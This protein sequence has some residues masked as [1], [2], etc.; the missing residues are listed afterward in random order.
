MTAVHDLVIRN[1][2]VVDGTGAAPFVADVA[3][4]DGRITSI[5]AVGVGAHEV[6][7]T[8]LLVTPGFVD[9]HTHF[10]GQATWDR[11]LTPS[12]WHGVTTAIA[13]NCGVGFAP[14]APGREAWLIELMEGVEDIPGSALSEGIRWGWESFPEYLAALDSVRED[15]TSDGRSLVQGAL[16]WIWTRSDRAIPIPGF[17][18]EQQVDDLIGSLRHGRLA[19]DAFERIE[20]AL[21]GRDAA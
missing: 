14:V 2:T 7:A 16:A 15:L 6:D 3:V 17:R 1:G 4:D 8:G 12:C 9:I 10:D 21:R 19:S 5:G 13:G 20:Q 11:H 18:N